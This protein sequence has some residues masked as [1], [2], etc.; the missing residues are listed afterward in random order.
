MELS[1]KGAIEANGTFGMKLS[2]LGK[3]YTY[4]L[5]LL[6]LSLQLFDGIATYQGLR[7]GV[8]EANPILVATFDQLG[9]A[10][11]LI[12]FKANACGLL[13]LL[14]RRPQH[15]LVFPTL[16]ILA[17]THISLSLVPWTVK[18][19]GIWLHAR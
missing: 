8:R 7:L 10:T 4:D 6:N 19:A 12:L 14:N 1:A 2:A 5:F 16:L 18:F 3:R 17:V 13:F 15:R 11:S 9:I